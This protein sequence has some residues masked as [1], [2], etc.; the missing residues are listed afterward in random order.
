V[1]RVSQNLSPFP[2]NVYMLM[3][4]V[5]KYR[6]FFWNFLVVFPLGRIFLV[7]CKIHSTVL[8]HLKG[9]NPL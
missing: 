6:R 9:S 5:P 4:D 7:G 2:L 8:P 3:R 1:P